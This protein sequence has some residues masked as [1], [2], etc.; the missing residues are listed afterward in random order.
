[1]REDP[2]RGVHT[3]VGCNRPRVG[4]SATGSVAPP[5]GV[6]GERAARGLREH[7]EVGLLEGFGPGAGRS[8]FLF[9]LFFLFSFLYIHIL[10]FKLQTSNLSLWIHHKS[11]CIKYTLHQYEIVFFLF[12]YFI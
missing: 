3:E 8:L 10:I 1:L 6:W 9:F 5:V 2:T 4:G 7:G 12:I 11:Q